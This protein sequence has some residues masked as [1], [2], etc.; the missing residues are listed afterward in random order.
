VSKA[1]AR[2]S[3]FPPPSASTSS[4]VLSMRGRSA[5]GFGNRVG[6]A[7]AADHSSK[8]AETEPTSDGDANEEGKEET[9]EKTGGSSSSSSS[10]SQA[11]LKKRTYY[12]ILGVGRKAT[13]EDVKIAYRKLAKKHHPDANLDNE[14]AEERF[15]EIQQA[16]A[17]LKD[18]WKRALYD[19]DLQFGSYGT[20]GTQKVDKEKWTEHWDRESPDEREARKDRYRRY[21]AGERNDL[22]PEPWP[23]R[24]TFVYFF[25]IV[26]TIFYICIKAPDWFDGQSDPTYCDPAYDDRSVP[27][28]RAFHDP[29]LNRWERLP[30]GAD[31]LSP[32]QLYAYYEKRRPDLMETIDLRILPKVS[33]TILMMP[34]TDTVKAVVRA[35]AASAASQG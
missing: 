31:P 32:K 25:V 1:E 28:V 11:P 14:D 2:W 18:K 34:R 5:L 33:L 23:L 10:G 7:S 16:H 17:T 27:L 19:Q 12:D 21:A 30:E 9:N 24:W 35:L 15:K 29:V 20:G 8:S 22:P 3:A 6:F 26:G 13:D 4:L